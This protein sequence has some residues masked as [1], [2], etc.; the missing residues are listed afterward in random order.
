[1][2]F[3][4][5]PVFEW[6]YKTFFLYLVACSI[7]LLQFLFP[8]FC[9][10]AFLLVCRELDCMRI[11]LFCF[12]F[13]SSWLFAQERPP[14]EVKSALTV[15]LG[16]PERITH[17]R[18]LS[19]EGEVAVR[20][21]AAVN[22]QLA[23]V[24]LS[25]LKADVG[26][27]VQAGQ[28]LALFDAAPLQQ[29]VAQ[30]QAA[31]NRAQ[32]VLAQAKRN[33]ARARK[34]VKDSAFSVNDAEQLFTAERDAQATLDGAQ[35]ALR[36]AQLRLGYAQVRAPVAGVIT[37][38]PAEVGM[39]AV[40]GLPLFTM[41][42]NGALEW[43]ARVAPDAAALLRPG[44]AAHLLA[45]DVAVS[46]RVRKLAPTVDAASR[47]A[48]VFVDVPPDTGLRAGMFVRGA[49][50]LGEE[51]V[52]TVPASAVVREDGYDLLVLAGDDNRVARRTVLLGERIGER[53]VVREGLAADAR[54]VLRGG[55]FLQDG[56]V[57]HV[58]GGE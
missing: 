15:Q 35:A 41:Q 52:L 17:E 48:T 56:D 45:G 42:V 28:V 50:A 18:T 20:E 43:R 1:M 55:S 54:F 30:A 26:D 53:V 33:A 51:A 36:L 38:R 29:E 37:A 39:T 24:T 16:V 44:M 4:A 19:A 49:F 14:A 40:V 57:V 6:S 23:G 7:S 25:Q 2:L 12:V 34:L 13:L 46:G 31:V 8:T 32:A 9:Y 47:L 10:T 5:P 58:V 21:L 27:R 11:F 3:S 22:A